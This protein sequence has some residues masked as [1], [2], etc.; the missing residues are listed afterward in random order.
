MRFEAI[1]FDIDNVLVDTRPSYLAAIQKTVERYLN[2]PGIITAK[3]VDHFKLLGG[4]ND[5]WDCCYGIVTFLE[6]AIQGKPVRFGDHRRG[7]LAISELGAIFPERPLGIDGLLKNLNVLYQKV[8]TPSYK[9]ISKIFQEVYLGKGQKISGLIR[10]EKLIFQKSFLRKIRNRG[11]RFGIVTGRNRFEATYALKRFG[12]LE[13]FDVLVTIDDVRRAEK[14]TGKILRKP[15]PWPI[16][17]AARRFR[18]GSRGLRFL[19]VGDLPDDILATKR[20]GRFLKIESAAFPKFARDH[21]ATLR[22]LK[23]VRPDFYLKEPR[24]LLKILFRH[25]HP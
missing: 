14:K 1:L 18:D 20:A 22:E 11:V 17:E 16:L 15:D 5:D 23:K 19:Y 6:T 24:D 10:K 8:E 21:E 12:I 25:F 9:R 2:R 3:D 13:L 7:R 4:F